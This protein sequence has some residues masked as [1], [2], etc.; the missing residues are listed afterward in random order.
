LYVSAP[1]LVGYEDV[2]FNYINI[3]R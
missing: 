3:V 2:V 1:E